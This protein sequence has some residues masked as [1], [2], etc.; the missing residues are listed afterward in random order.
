MDL[1][2]LRG[3]STAGE[4]VGESLKGPGGF[5]IRQRLREILVQLR[6]KFRTQRV[7]I[8]L[9]GERVRVAQDNLDE[10]DRR[11][12]SLIVRAPHDGVLVE[13]TA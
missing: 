13:E 5:G 4:H 3:M 1:Q 6:R 2:P 8:R 12:A 7:V 11:I 10:I 9:A